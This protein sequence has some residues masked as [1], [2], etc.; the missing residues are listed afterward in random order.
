MET[1]TGALVGIAALMTLYHAAKPNQ[2]PLWIPLL[3]VEI[4]ILLKYMPVG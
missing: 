3:L 4:A 1:L 2:L